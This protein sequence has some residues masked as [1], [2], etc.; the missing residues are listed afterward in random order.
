MLRPRAVRW[1]ICCNRTAFWSAARSRRTSDES[2]LVCS[3]T[4]TRR[5]CRARASS[6]WTRGVGAR[7]ARMHRSYEFTSVMYSQF[8]EWFS[9]WILMNTNEVMNTDE[10][11]MMMMMSFVTRTCNK[12]P[13]PHSVML[14][15]CHCSSWN[16]LFHPYE[17]SSA[18]DDLIWYPYICRGRALICAGC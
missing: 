14:C 17:Y 11:M 1:R 13:Q 5:G 16:H 7:E 8:A 4:S 3:A 10:L 18:C 12:C 15:H 6:R 2:Q 9:S